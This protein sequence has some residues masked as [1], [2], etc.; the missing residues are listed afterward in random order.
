MGEVPGRRRQA[1]PDGLHWQ[2]PIRYRCQYW[3]EQASHTSLA[4]GGDPAVQGWPS[5][6]SAEQSG[7]L[8][9]GPPPSDVEVPA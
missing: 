6:T 7:R 5:T 1:H 9:S 8:S 2:G 4:H 3:S